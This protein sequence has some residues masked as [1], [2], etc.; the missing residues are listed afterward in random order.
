[1]KFARRHFVSVLFALGA[2]LTVTAP[3]LAQVAG[4]DYTLITPEQQSG[5]SGKIEVIEFFGYFCP[6]CRDAAPALH[7]WAGK[8]PAD[9]VLKKVP[10]SF[11]RPVLVNWQ[12]LYYTLEATGDLARLDMAAFKAAQDER[13]PLASE[14]EAVAWAV[15][16][17]IDKKKF[18]DAWK[19]FS[20]VSNVKRAG[21]LERDYK[22]S[23]V[24]AIAVGGKYMS[25]DMAFNDKLLVAD[26]LIAK[27]RAEKSGKK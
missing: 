19:S 25:G 12:R 13:L 2:A 15:R 7:A 9:V 24:P 8:L 26:K 17:G 18:S 11:N 20:V 14:E 21:Q 5:D 16:N 23:G 6:H 1:M 4:K 3:A 10:V 27:I 22:V